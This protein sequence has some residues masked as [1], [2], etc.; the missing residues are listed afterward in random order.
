MSD[1]LEEVIR[2]E[3]RKAQATRADGNLRVAHARTDLERRLRAAGCAEVVVLYRGYARMDGF[4][5]PQALRI[6]A[7]AIEQARDATNGQD[8]GEP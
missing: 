6:I 2:L 1:D 4:F 8:A 5:E 7:D 3:I